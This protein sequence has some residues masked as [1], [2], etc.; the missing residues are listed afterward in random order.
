M[1]FTLAAL[2]MAVT[3]GGREAATAVEPAPQQQRRMK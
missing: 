1:K 3:L 2:L